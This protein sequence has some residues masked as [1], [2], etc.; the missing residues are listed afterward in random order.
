MKALSRLLSCTAEP[1]ASMH[2]QVKPHL[3]VGTGAGVGSSFYNGVSSQWTRGCFACQRL[4]SLFGI[5][6]DM[7]MLAFISLVRLG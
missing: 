1:V 2:C 7:Y 3:C 5:W 4:Q 6:N